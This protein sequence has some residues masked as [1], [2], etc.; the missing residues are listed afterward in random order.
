MKVDLPPIRRDPAEILADG[1]DRR[2][3]VLVLGGVLCLGMALGLELFPHFAGRDLKTVRL[4]PT[5]GRTIEPLAELLVIPEPPGA[6]AKELTFGQLIQILSAKR[7]EPAAGRFVREFFGSAELKRAFEDFEKGSAER[8]AAEFV[9]V[10]QRSAEFGDLMRSHSRQPEFRGLAEGLTK[11][12]ELN[13]LLRALRS[14]AA[15]QAAP[16]PKFAPSDR[17]AETLEAEFKGRSSP[18]GTIKAPG[19]PVP[20]DRP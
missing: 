5:A 9:S 6:P 10:L 7:G 2:L 14:P 12:P 17:G 20:P 13:R 16:L 1:L 3:V 11:H 19:G 18:V 15:P 4:S 8:P